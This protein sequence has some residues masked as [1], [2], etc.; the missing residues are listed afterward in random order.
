ML[1]WC[2]VSAKAFCSN[3]T[4]CVAIQNRSETE[5]QHYYPIVYKLSDLTANDTG[6]KTVRIYLTSGTHILHRDLFLSNSVQVTEIHGAPH[7]PPSIIE[8]RNNSGIRFSENESANKILISNIM[9]ILHCQRVAP[10]YL[11]NARYVLSGVT[12]SNPVGRGV[13]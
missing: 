2:A 4:V 5:C 11:I 3:D 8:C 7:G 6:C 9:I 13:I 10:L 12:V 1:L